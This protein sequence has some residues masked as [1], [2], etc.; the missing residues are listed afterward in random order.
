MHIEL[1]FNIRDE[2]VSEKE[3]KLDEINSNISDLEHKLE[4]MIQLLQ[5]TEGSIPIL[6]IKKAKTTVI[7]ERQPSEEEDT[8][9]IAETPHV[10]SLEEGGK[11]EFKS[12]S[13][14]SMAAMMDEEK[15]PAT[16][17][18][19]SHVDLDEEELL[20]EPKEEEFDDELEVET[21]K[22]QENEELEEV[23]A[24]MEEEEGENTEV[25]HEEQSSSTE[26]VSKPKAEARKTQGVEPSLQQGAPSQVVVVL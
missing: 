5:T 4:L 25:V 11:D 16:S 8:K 2:S 3:A 10:K 20:D 17:A 23:E 19:E 12:G 14:S 7:K 13:V 9:S 18:D 26:G 21:S 6:S 15:P 22:D 1:F 24:A